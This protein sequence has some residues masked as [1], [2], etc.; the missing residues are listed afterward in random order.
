ML[1]IMN[2]VNIR[3]QNELTEQ[4]I[5]KIKKIIIDYYT[6]KEIENDI[7]E[8]D[9]ISMLFVQELS[10]IEISSRIG[11]STRQIRRRRNKYIDYFIKIVDKYV[12][13]KQFFQKRTENVPH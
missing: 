6:L 10:I 13:E 9:L 8:L 4:D 5:E 3:L 7:N 2:Y 1:K 11:L 12:K